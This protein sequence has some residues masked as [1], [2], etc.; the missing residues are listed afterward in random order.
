MERKVILAT[1]NRSRERGF[2]AT[3]YRLN[4]Q[5]PG[6]SGDPLSTLFTSPSQPGQQALVNNDNPQDT[7]VQDTA[8][9][10]TDLHNSNI[11]MASPQGREGESYPQAPS[12]TESEISESRGSESVGEILSRQGRALSGPRRS[13]PRPETETEEW[14]SIQAYIIDFARLLGDAASTKSSTSRAYRLY[15]ASGLSIEAFIEK[16]YQ[17]RALTQEST[18][19]ITKMHTDDHGYTRKAKMPYFFAVLA[20]QLKPE[21]QRNTRKGRGAS[22]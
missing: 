22:T 21:D 5:Q 6:S 15:S 14:Q 11:R 9:Q 17:A 13:R 4:V 19:S 7:V 3:T 12:A 8:E 16:M 10:E 2:E 18:A 1:A 20:D